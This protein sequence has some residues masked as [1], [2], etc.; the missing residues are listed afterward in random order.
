MC[1]LSPCERTGSAPLAVIQADADDQYRICGEGIPRA[2]IALRAARGPGGAGRRAP[3][4]EHRHAGLEPHEDSEKEGSR[5]RKCVASRRP[6]MPFAS[7]S[8]R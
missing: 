7:D 4:V 8:M 5:V 6:T 2:A 1:H 3:P